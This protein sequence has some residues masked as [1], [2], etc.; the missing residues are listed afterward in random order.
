MGA[1]VWVVEG[2]REGYR[3]SFL[4]SPPLAQRP[5]GFGTY[6]TGSVR[7]E[8]LETEVQ[9]LLNKGAIELAP[10]GPGFYSRLFVVPKATGGFRPV[11][12]LSI[13]NTFVQKTYFRMET[14]RSVLDSVRQDDWMVSLD[15]QDAYFQ[16]PVH[17]DSR[18]FLRFLWRDQVFQF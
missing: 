13:L 9:Q 16:V 12:D 18:K 5:M 15:L 2:L 14:V 4:K 6:W 1:E 10:G 11:L 17:Q 7:A 3:I 8:A